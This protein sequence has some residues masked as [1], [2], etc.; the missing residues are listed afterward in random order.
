MCY[1]DVIKEKGIIVKNKKLKLARIEK[2]LTQQ[3]LANLVGVTRQTIGL[4]EAKNYNPSLS[5]CISICQ[6]LGK[7]LDEI[8]WEDKDYE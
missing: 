1:N 3:D 5:L 8:F 4:I 7:T 2:D 6:V